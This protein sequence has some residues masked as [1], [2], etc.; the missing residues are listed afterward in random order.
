MDTSIISVFDKEGRACGARERASSRTC[1][2]PFSVIFEKFRIE[3]GIQANGLPTT[4]GS[5]VEEES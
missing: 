1:I 5:L 2:R 4:Q 3:R